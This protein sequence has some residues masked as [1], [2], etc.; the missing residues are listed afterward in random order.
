MSSDPFNLSRFVSQH[1]S[2]FSQAMKELR[3]GHKSS[4]WS[5]YLLPTPPF[6]RNGVEVGSGINRMYAL[7]TDEEAQAYLTFVHPTVSLRRNYLDMMTVVAEQLGP[8]N[9]VSPTRLMGIDV[10]RLQASVAYF[11]RVS[12]EQVPP[13]G[14]LNAACLAVMDGLKME[15]P[16]AVAPRQPAAAA[17]RACSEPTAAGGP[18]GD[19]EDWPTDSMSNEAPPAA[20]QSSAPASMDSAPKL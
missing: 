1:G 15:R 7:R 16:G 4:C 3:N 10:P 11:E 13:D 19:D 8:P 20:R 17:A 2:H 5:W 9:P 6:I 14:E 12:R 18:A